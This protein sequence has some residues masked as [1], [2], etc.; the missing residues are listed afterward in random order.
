MNRFISRG[1]IYGFAAV[2]LLLGIL[3][4]AS[5]TANALTAGGA[6]DCSGWYGR[7]CIRGY[8]TNS[9]EYA[10]SQDLIN[11]GSLRMIQT[12]QKQAFIDLIVSMLNSGDKKNTTVAQFYIL[13]MLGHNGGVPKSV[14][15][16]QLQDWKNRIN[17][18]EIEMVRTTPIFE[19]GVANTFYQ[20]FADDIAADN[21]L[22][23]WGCGSLDQMLDFRHNGALVYRIRVACGNPMNNS[24]GLPPIPPTITSCG[25]LA[26]QPTRPEFGDS[27]VLRPTIRFS[28]GPST[29][30]LSN[31][32]ISVNNQSGLPGAIGATGTIS[33]GQVNMTSASFTVPSAGQYTVRWGAT[34]NG[35]LVI[36][37]GLF[38][39][40]D[41]F[42]VMAYPFVKVNGGDTYSGVSFAAPYRSGEG[43]LPCSAAS[44]NPKAGVVS[45]NTDTGSYSGAGGSY[46]V[47]AMGYIQSYAS[48]QGKAR[49]PA[50]LNFSNVD[51]PAFGSSSLQTS[52]GRFGGLFGTAPCMDYWERKPADDKLTPLN[53][54]A[55]LDG[56]TGH[57]VLNGNLT[58]KGALIQTG[59]RLTIY[60]KGDVNI[61]GDVVYQN[62]I[63]S[64]RDSADV[65]SFTLIVNGRIF[66]ESTVSQLDGLYVGVPNSNYVNGPS[67]FADPAVGSIITCS[68]GFS[69]HNP[70]LAATSNMTS[71][72]NRRLTVNGGFIANHV[73]LLRTFGTLRTNEPAEVFNYTPELWLAPSAIDLNTPYD[74]LT[75]LPP[76]L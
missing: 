49:G 28:G 14:S 21:V 69:A 56:L 34:I 7:G 43:L 9:N 13:S 25:V 33:N 64:W 45:S 54:S 38:S 8:F 62:N 50:S 75:A 73:L 17:D 52:A 4:A 57:Y 58:I 22:A 44:H 27:I 10:T 20:T 3:F 55:T 5:Q 70:L 53:P 47:F 46:A 12:G 11:N 67:S 6:S 59:R 63:T 51:Y 32:T 74:T 36:C 29:P 18:P 31:P 24:P 16:A 40:S 68:N 30:K 65:P 39:P 66:V 60:V 1:I 19:C 76:V 61:R 15:A 48:D 42:T 35:V 72:C 23:S 2:A 26:V 41:S 37:G 71:I